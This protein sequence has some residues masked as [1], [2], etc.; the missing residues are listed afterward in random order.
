MSDPV[1]PELEQERRRHHRVE[2]SAPASFLANDAIR[3]ARCVSLSMGGANLR[4][5][6][7]LRAGAMLK[8]KVNLSTGELRTMAE[9]VRS[10]GPN[11]GVRFTQLDQ[12]SMRAILSSVR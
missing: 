5:W 9:V 7:T 11:I 4:T 10:E 6:A 1:V 8:L 2:V 3:V 12:D